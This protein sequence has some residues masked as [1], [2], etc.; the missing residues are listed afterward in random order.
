MV[1]LQQRELRLQ[2]VVR[3]RTPQRIVDPY[4]QAVAAPAGRLQV[5]SQL[6]AGK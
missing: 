6:V 4:Q 3:P 2:Q 5:A 1:T